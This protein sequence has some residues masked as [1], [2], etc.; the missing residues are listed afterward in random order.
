MNI[1]ASYNA[2]HETR[3]VRRALG[4]NGFKRASK[5]TK[6]KF[7]RVVLTAEE[8]SELNEAN[9]LHYYNFPEKEG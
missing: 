9:P 3:L 4:H 6:P 7:Q 5:Q 8:C 1:T 2:I